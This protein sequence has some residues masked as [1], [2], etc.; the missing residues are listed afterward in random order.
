MNANDAVGGDDVDTV[1][2]RG[3]S[4]VLEK[5]RDLRKTILEVPVSDA[6]VWFRN[7]LLGILN[8]AL[9]DYKSVEIGVE[10]S[11]Y[12]AAWGCR[13]LLELKVIATYVL[14]SEK[15]AHD[16]QNDLL[17]D[18]K[19]FYEAVTKSHEAT[20]TQLLS[21][22]S[23]AAE[24]EEGHMKE[25]LEEASRK[26]AERGPQTEATKTA[27]SVYEQMMSDFGVKKDARPKRASDI[28]RL[29]KV[30]ADFNPMFK[31]CS[32]IMHRTALSIASS[33]MPAS[34]DEVNPFLR[35]RSASDLLMIYDSIS[36]HVE[37]KGLRPPEN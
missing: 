1:V 13:N 37:K 15:N 18:A 25:V 20:Q 17:I 14:A 35:N 24:Q 34:L 26:E 11:S 33:T 3:L 29:I 6:H 16:F 22:L 9:L 27:A 4:Q 23:E 28:A 21:M 7:L 36:K 8:C 2:S 32:K 10:K 30:E 5:V 12:L 31:V 19:E